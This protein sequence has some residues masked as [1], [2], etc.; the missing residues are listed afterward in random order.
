VTVAVDEDDLPTTVP[1]I[2][3]H[4]RVPVSDPLAFVQ[5]TRVLPLDT[6]DGVRIDVIFALLP[7]ELDAIRRAKEVTIADRTVHVVTPE[8]LI[9]M[10]IISERPRDVADA[11]AIVRRRIGDL[12]LAY[13]EPRIRELATALESDAIL[14]RWRKWTGGDGLSGEDGLV[15]HAPAIRSDR[16]QKDFVGT[17]LGVHDLVDALGQRG[18]EARAKRQR[19]RRP[20]PWRFRRS[21]TRTTAERAG[22]D[23][24]GFELVVRAH[25]DAEGFADARLKDVDGQGLEAVRHLRIL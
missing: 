11:E 17:H 18:S 5:Q 6:D 4:F 24:L 23:E 9:L 22:F 19:E 21:A 12:D 8:D 7:F 3:R 13:L 20:S 10:K 14:N 2:A 25:A 1:A 15:H 16:Y